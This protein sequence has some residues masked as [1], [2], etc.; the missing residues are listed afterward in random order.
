MP[1]EDLIKLI[2][3]P[4]CGQRKPAHQTDTHMCVDCSHAISNR[5]T[6]YRQHNDWMA[7][8]REQGLDTWLQQPGET[9]WEYTVWLAY[10]DSYPGKKPT[11]GAVAVQLGT[12]YAAV[13]NIARRWDFQA[14][15][16]MWMTECDRITMLQRRVEI[17]DMNKEHVDMAARLRAKLS[18]AIDNIDPVALKPGE[19]ASLAKVSADM[20]RKARV[21]TVAQEEMRRELVSDSGNPDL[22]KTPTK[23]GDL[24]EVV[25]ILLK[26]GALG[27]ITKIGIRETKTTEVALVDSDG[28]C[29]SLGLEGDE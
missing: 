18:I 20:E 29:S 26:A 2:D 16:Q 13:K 27:E 28:N 17:L 10:R 11:Y 15:M 5:I 14:R 12:T 21:D 22:K 24:A 9:Q 8:A 3:C 19:I 7:E 4:K 25:Q 6:Y 23:Q 1:D